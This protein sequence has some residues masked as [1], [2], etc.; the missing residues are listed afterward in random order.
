MLL[1]SDCY[2]QLSHGIYTTPVDPKKYFKNPCPRTGAIPEI[3][4]INGQET[5]KS[6][7]NH[8]Y[9]GIFRA[10]AKVGH[11][12]YSHPCNNQPTCNPGYSSYADNKPICVHCE[13]KSDHGPYSYPGDDDGDDDSDDSNDDSDNDDVNDS[14]N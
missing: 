1:C 2:N 6:C 3:I 4:F 10:P 14:D 11:P 8:S 7:L 13:N 9:H 5:C 12:Y